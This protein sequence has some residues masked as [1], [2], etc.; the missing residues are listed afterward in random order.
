MSS[1]DHIAVNYDHHYPVSI[2]STK[3]ADPT[4]QAV[5]TATEIMVERSRPKP[6]AGCDPSVKKKERSL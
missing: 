5:W 3:P 1:P 6:A 2:T 4:P